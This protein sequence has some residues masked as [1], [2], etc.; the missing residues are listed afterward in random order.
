MYSI[1]ATAGHAV[2]R[3]AVDVN[4]DRM[5]LWQAENLSWF[6]EFFKPNTASMARQSLL[7]NCKEVFKVFV[8]SVELT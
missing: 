8:Y 3:F 4:P 2:Y 5:M 1:T 7:H 6:R